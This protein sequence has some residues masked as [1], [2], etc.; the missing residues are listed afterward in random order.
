MVRPNGYHKPSPCHKDDELVSLNDLVNVEDM[1]EPTVD[2]GE[3]LG[4]DHVKRLGSGV[5]LA[6][7]SGLVVAVVL[8]SR[9]FLC[10]GFIRL[11]K[12]HAM[13]IGLLEL[14]DKGNFCRF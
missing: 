3:D 14:G 2:A 6:L 13:D 9:E 4:R 7:F 11:S 10:P 8:F 1:F 5:C 12:D